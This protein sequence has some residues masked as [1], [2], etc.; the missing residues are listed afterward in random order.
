MKFHSAI[1]A[2]GTPVLPA[3]RHRGGKI[4]T[5]IGVG[6]ASRLSYFLTLAA[7]RKIRNR[8]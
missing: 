3:G 1:R 2:G 6:Q 4:E 5:T 7:A 8:P